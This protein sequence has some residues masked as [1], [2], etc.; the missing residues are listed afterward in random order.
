M[1]TCFTGSH[2][3][4]DVVF[5]LLKPNLKLSMPKWS[6][7]D[8]LL[9]TANSLQFSR[10]LNKWGSLES[11]VI[12]EMVDLFLHSQTSSHRILGIY[13][14]TYITMTII[15]QVS[16]CQNNEKHIHAHIYMTGFF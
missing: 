1:N 12:D 13:G 6:Q 10:E 9:K 7:R 4:F 14:T 5:F 16:Q 15:L 2:K 8:V 3:Y 11:T